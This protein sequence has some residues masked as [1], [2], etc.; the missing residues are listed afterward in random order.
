MNPGLIQ[1]Y[2]PWA[3]ST[4]WTLGSFNGFS[5]RLVAPVTRALSH[6]DT[7]AQVSPKRC[8]HTKG[9]SVVSREEAVLRIKAACDAEAV[10]DEQE[11][12]LFCNSIPGYK[13]A[14]L[15]EGGLTPLLS[16]SRLG[17]IGYCLAAYPITLLSAAL[18]GMTSSLKAIKDGG[19]PND[20]RDRSKNPILTFEE[21]KDI[22]GFTSFYQE[23][24]KYA[25]AG[26]STDK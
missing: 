25:P 17:E 20:L 7:N 12:E 15:I 22:V 1:P 24:V 21:V 14:N 13:M 2:E 4:V 9:K 18:K 16:Q 8:G 26:T 10:R 19:D 6:I 23:E 3:H 11:M 5:E